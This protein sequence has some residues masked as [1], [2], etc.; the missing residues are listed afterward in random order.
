MVEFYLVTGAAGNLGSSVVKELL[1]R[2]KR[3]RAL[4]LKGDAAAQRLPAEVEQVEGNILSTADLERFFAVPTGT[5]LNVIHCAGLVAT[6]WGYDEKVCQVNVQ[7]TKN[8]VNQCLQSRVKKFVYTSSVHAI[9]EEPGGG[10]MREITE[11]QPEKIVGF[12]GKSKAMASQAVME[13]FRQEDLNATVV[14][15]SGLCGP[16]DYAYGYVTQLLMDSAA[17]KLPAGVK[18][19][20]DFAD[21]RDVAAG[22][23]AAC[24]QGKK[25]ET[26]ILGNR[27]VTV[28]EI[29]ELVHELTGAKLVTRM[30]P[31]GFARLLLP[32]FSLYYALNRCRPLF[33]RYSLYTLTSNA[34]FSSQ[35]AKEELGYRAR[36]FRET[37]RDTL[38]WLRR[39]GKIN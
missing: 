12:Y 11:F 23:V 14:F 36:P 35:K 1:D 31:V 39:E 7:G 30:I 27:Y 10:L 15:P 21:V 34:N 25:G 37:V 26:Y 20:Y 17:G 24:Q 13:A 32:F 9:P 28:Q 33:T 19:G 3:I 18:G 6:V 2:G 16:E 22:V 8:V 4:V 38:D 5:E 29:M